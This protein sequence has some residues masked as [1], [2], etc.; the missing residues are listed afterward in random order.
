MKKLFQLTI[1]LFTI[2][3][4]S[5]QAFAQEQNPNSERN[6][7][8]RLLQS[9]GIITEQEAAMISEASSPAQAER[10]LAELLVSKGVITR[11]EYE[12][13][14]LA[15]GASSTAS[16]SAAPRVVA[17]AHRVGW[18]S[19]SRLDRV[20]RVDIPADW[21]NFVVA[22]PQPHFIEPLFTR[23]PATGEAALYGDVA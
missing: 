21:V 19:V 2:A 13:T 3:A 14:R 5:D 7:L 18:T 23:D 10:R 16:D 1:L 11:Q 17:A 9:K 20:P 8:V 12:Q 15:L 4:L 6:P 22:S